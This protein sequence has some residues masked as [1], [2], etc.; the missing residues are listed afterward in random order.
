MLYST[1][2]RRAYVEQTSVLDEAHEV[3]LR[4]LVGLPRDGGELIG[5]DAVQMA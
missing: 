2:H 3:L 1:V 5:H 4:V